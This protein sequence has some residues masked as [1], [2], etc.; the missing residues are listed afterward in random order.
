MVYPWSHIFCSQNTFYILGY[1]AVTINCRLS[2]VIIM[3]DSFPS[4]KFSLFH[5]SNYLS[6]F[7]NRKRPA[8]FSLGSFTNAYW[9]QCSQSCIQRRVLILQAL[10]FF[11]FYV[12]S[13]KNYYAGVQTHLRIICSYSNAN[14]VRNKSDSGQL[15]PLL[16]NLPARSSAHAVVIQ[17]CFSCDTVTL[18]S[19]GALCIVEILRNPQSLDFQYQNTNFFS[20]NS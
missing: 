17:L 16:C 11:Q 6:L 10:S 14:T 9:S 7:L 3:S 20:P 4:H 5:T 1:K 18:L 12:S 8:A 19:V 15:L 13:N 2:I